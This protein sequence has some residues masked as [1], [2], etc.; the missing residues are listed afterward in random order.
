MG[1]LTPG[2][3]TTLLAWLLGLV[4][5]AIIGIVAMHVRI[6]VF[7]QRLID[8]MT[9]CHELHTK[10]EESIKELRAGIIQSLM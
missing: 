9:I 10:H 2:V 4:T 7:S 3:I 5:V 6:S 8:H 1:E